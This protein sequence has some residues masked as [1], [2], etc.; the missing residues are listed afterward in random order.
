MRWKLVRDNIPNIIK[1]RG[2]VPVTQVVSES[3]MKDLLL[4]KLNEEV[5]EV[6][7]DLNAEELADVM[8]IV[9]ALGKQIGESKE[10]LEIKR[11]AKRQKN[12]GFEDRVLLQLP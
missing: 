1:S 9:Y 12:G 3:E 2:E 10:S 7:A 11:L 8:E 5:Q 6:N 4:A